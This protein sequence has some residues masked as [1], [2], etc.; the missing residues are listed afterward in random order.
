MVM[1]ELIPLFPLEIQLMIRR[2]SYELDRSL[3][4]QRWIPFHDLSLEA[5]Q[6]HA[7]SRYKLK[8]RYFFKPQWHAFD[9]DDGLMYERCLVCDY[10]LNY[11]ASVFGTRPSDLY[12]YKHCHD[13][14]FLD[15]LLFHFAI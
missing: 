6:M 5:K 7:F 14:G 1:R 9:E 11:F 8:E 12:M 13:C 2:E 10:P 3:L 15:R 4:E